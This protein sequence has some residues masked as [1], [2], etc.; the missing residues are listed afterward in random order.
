M[1]AAARKHIRCL[2][3]DSTDVSAWCR[4]R[5]GYGEFTIMFCRDCRSSFVWLEPRADLLAQFY[6]PP[7]PCTATYEDLLEAERTYPNATVDAR[8]MCERCRAMRSGNK[9]LDIGAGH[10]FFSRTA[11]DLGFTVTA[12]EPSPD[13]REVYRDLNGFEPQGLAFDDR[14]VQSRGGSFDAVLLVQVL[15]HLPHP[16]AVLRDI[17]DVLSTDGMA[18]IAVSHFASV[19]SRLQGR[20]G[21]FVIPPEHLNYL[22]E[23]GLVALCERSG[24]T[25]VH[26]ET[27]SRFDTARVSRR[28][29]VPPGSHAL[30]E[31]VLLALRTL[32]VLGKGMFLNAYIGKRS[33]KVG[34]THGNDTRRSHVHA[35]EG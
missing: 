23:S 26:L 28:L 22:S 8:R 15:E 11:L 25:L 16:V 20:H 6:A 24:F 13:R 12:C 34:I 18:A 7:S 3:C 17:G 5:N 4:K 35:I 33:D 2:A 27:I 30:A 19:L 21:M 29:S 31:G 14:F 9:L 10:G 32:D 1:I